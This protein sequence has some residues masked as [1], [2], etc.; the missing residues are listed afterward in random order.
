MPPQPA[1]AAGAGACVQYGITAGQVSECR[2]A[3]QGKISE[4]ALSGPLT[5]RKLS[6][7]SV[8]SALA[9]SVFEQ[10]GGP[11]LQCKRYVDRPCSCSP[12]IAPIQLNRADGQ[13]KSR[14]ESVCAAMRGRATDA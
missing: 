5:A 7:A 8:A 3:S 9:I 1:T 4:R 11:Y 14:A 12:A 10:P 6:P 13:R 2:A